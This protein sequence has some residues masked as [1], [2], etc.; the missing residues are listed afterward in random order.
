MKYFA[1]ISVIGILLSLTMVGSADMSACSDLSHATLNLS[2]GNFAGFYY[3]AEHGVC[4]ESLS[5][6]LSNIAPDK[7]K[8][9]LSGQLNEIGRRGVTY[10]MKA[11]P[12]NFGFKLWGQYEAIEF[13]GEPYMAAY[14][15]VQTQAMAAAGETVPFL[16]SRSNNANLMA[17]GQICKV[18]MDSGTATSITSSSPL[19]LM[20]GYQLAVKSIDVKGNKLYLELSKNGQVVDS[21]V[22]QPSIKDAKV[23]DGTYYY[24]KNLEGS[25]GI[26]TIAV[27]FRPNIIQI[28]GVGTVVYVDGVYQISDIPAS[29]KVDQQ[30]DKLTIKTVDIDSMSIEMDNKDYQIT[31]SNNKYIPLTG[32]LYIKTANQS[33][34]NTYRPL[35][36]CVYKKV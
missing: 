6:I 5:L 1:L 8:A 29:I 11:H 7:S 31:L 26:V 25:Q 35:K 17:S 22:I 33:I 27:H 16:A 4:T 30:Y 12:K 21:K 28:K 10:Y 3:D 20:E 15:N 13:L 18:L 9:T 19:K 14:D 34:I 32:K 2:C 23:A 24:K 36:Y